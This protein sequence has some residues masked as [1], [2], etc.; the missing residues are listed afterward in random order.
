MYLT[1]AACIFKNDA[2]IAVASRENNL[3]Y[4]AALSIQLRCIKWR[5][6]RWPGHA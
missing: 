2:Q 4:F 6:T 5:E 3:E 1:N